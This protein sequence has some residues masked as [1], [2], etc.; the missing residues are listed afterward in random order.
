[1]PEPVVAVIGAGQSG[2]Q[3]A[4]SLRQEGFAGRIVLI[5]DEPGLP[6]QRPPL[7]KSYLPGESGLEE[8]WLRPEAFYQKQEIDLFTG[9]TATAIDR[10]GHRRA[11]RLGQRDRVRSHR[12]GD[13]CA[14]PSRAGAGRRTRWCVAIAHLG[15]CRHFARAARPRRAKS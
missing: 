8:L 4:S 9:E 5:G 12:A 15:R 2:F 11:T 3:A 14:M 13:G 10:P 1:M 7:S 6:Y